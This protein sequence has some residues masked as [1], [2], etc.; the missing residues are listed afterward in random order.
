[1]FVVTDTD[2]SE[3]NETINDKMSS[4]LKE[5]L[6]VASKLYWT[7]QRVIVQRNELMVLRKM[8]R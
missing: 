5:S 1:M 7:D 6:G 2:E 8:I 4:Y 3:I